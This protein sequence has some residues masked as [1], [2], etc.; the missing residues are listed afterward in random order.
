[1]ARKRVALIGVTGYGSVHY[2]H[3]VQLAERGL[4][5][6][7]AVVIINPE[8]AADKVARLQAMGTRIFGSTADL[9]AAMAG[10]LDI[11]FIPTGIHLHEPMTLQALRAGANVLVEKPASGTID[12]VRRMLAAERETGKWVA[13][14]FQHI[15]AP[16]VHVIKKAIVDGDI[17]RIQSISFLG[18]WPRSDAYYNRNNWAGK[19]ACNDIWILDSPANNAFAHYTNLALF[20]GGETFETMARIQTVQAELYRA[21][22]IESFDTCSI[23]YLTTAGFPICCNLTHSSDVSVHPE[24]R[25]KGSRGTIFWKQDSSY[26]ITND[27][28]LELSGK[29]KQPHEFLFAAAVAKLDEPDTF[30][31]TLKMAGN[32]VYCLNAVHMA[33][34]P[35]DIPAAYVTIQPEDG[36]HC[37]AG[38]ADSLTQAYQQGKL[39]SEL[40]TVAW[41]K[42]SAIYPCASMDRFTGL[43]T[44]DS[45][46][47]S[48]GGFHA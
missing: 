32:Q 33:T 40:G 12:S 47:P 38:I 21:R 11:V 31:C 43:A 36:T 45:L 4:L 6:L 20:F 13:V 42:P 10:D 39:L 16:E 3:V 17:G 23:R 27:D 37:V 29:V 5:E 35:W 46:A 44:Q 14:G 48:S 2:T 26:T 34:S 24:I 18:V 15:S 41:A 1:M 25:I 8:E 7:S 30:L 19:L 9:Y 22:P 28:G